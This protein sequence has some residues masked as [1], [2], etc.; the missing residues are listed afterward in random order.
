MIDPKLLRSDPEAVAA[1]LARRGFKLDVA[2]LKSL[3][4]QLS[5]DT[6][7]LTK[8]EVLQLTRERDKLEKSLGGIRDMGGLPEI[9][10]VVDTNKEELAIKE[11][12]VLGIPVVAILDSNS[13]PSGIA[14]P[15]PG[16]DDASRAIRLYTDAI[17][18]AVGEGRS[19]QAQAKGQ[20]IGEMAE[21]PVE[22]ALEA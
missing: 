1:N 9:M 5:G 20:D 22:P 18:Q 10:F 6:A 21:P 3:E 15:V 19:G 4:E 7:G 11:A 14:F 13:D 12:N 8:K 2:R 17:S 16:N